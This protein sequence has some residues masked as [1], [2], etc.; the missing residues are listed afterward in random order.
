MDD[1]RRE[2][3]WGAFLLRFVLGMM[4]FVAGIGKFIMGLGVFRGFLAKQFAE[5]W[6]PH[7][8]VAPFGAV[9]PFV[10]VIVGALLILGLAR[11]FSLIAG[12]LLML[13]LAFGTMVSNNQT[14]SASNVVFVALFAAALF[15]SRWDLIALDTLISRPR[16]VENF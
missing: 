5:S 3:I 9:L 7:I 16:A 10:E 12:S 13:T 1:I 8:I 4:F 6:L 14:S 2:F 11:F 15:A